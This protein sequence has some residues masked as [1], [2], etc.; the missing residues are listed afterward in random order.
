MSLIAISVRM[1]KD[2]EL[3]LNCLRP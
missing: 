2:S 1:L 3:L